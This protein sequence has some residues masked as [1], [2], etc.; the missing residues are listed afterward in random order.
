MKDK[1]VLGIDPDSAKHG[2]AIYS[3]SRLIELCKFNLMELH[4][5]INTYKQ[6]SNISVTMENVLKN[7]FIYRRN[8]K[9]S[10]AANA[11][12]G[13]SVGRCQQAQ[14]EL[15]RLF[16]YHKIPYQLIAPSSGNWAKDK[17]QFQAITGWEKQS[18][19]DTRS[20]AFF[21][22]LGARQIW[23]F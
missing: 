5:F 9:D 23:Q 15:M 20:A 13:I 18:N 6:L 21:G 14:M 4:D 11:K 2:V 19:E 3:N 17:K 7:K 22:F 16:D 12:V 10:L 8:T 1:L